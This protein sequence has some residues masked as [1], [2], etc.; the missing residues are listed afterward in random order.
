MNKKNSKT[1]VKPTIKIRSSWN[2]NEVIRYV[3][4]KYGFNSNDYGNRF[5]NSLKGK[6]TKVD[7]DVPYLDFW[8]WLL[9]RCQI[10]NG[11]TISF[12]IKD[13]LKEECGDDE[14]AIKPWIKEILQYIY[15]EFGEDE[16][17]MYI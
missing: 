3:E 11:V 12:Y 7:K 10:N 9:E 17:E 13:W 15:D 1:L 16:M 4:Q 14:W 2:Y 8:H 6:P 5:R